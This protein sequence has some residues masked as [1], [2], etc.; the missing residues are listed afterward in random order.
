[1]RRIEEDGEVRARDVPAEM[2]SSLDQHVSHKSPN[3]SFCSAL[4]PFESREGLNCA[5]RPDKA[6]DGRLTSERIMRTRSA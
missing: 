5:P 6:A 1:M 3:F 2:E 4:V